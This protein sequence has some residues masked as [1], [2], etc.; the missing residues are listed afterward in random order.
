MFSKKKIEKPKN[1]IG[2][3][4]YDYDIIFKKFLEKQVKAVAVGKKINISKNIKLFG[5]IS[6]DFNKMKDDLSK[7]KLKVDYRSDKARDM[8]LE[9]INDTEYLMYIIKEE[10]IIEEKD[11]LNKINE[12]LKKIS[13]A[14]ALIRGKLRDIE[15]DY[16]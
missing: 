1:P 6:S 10:K 3:V 5:N 14:R 12:T 4:L 2:L 11:K 15:C 9:M 13:D 8:I 7:E 16:T